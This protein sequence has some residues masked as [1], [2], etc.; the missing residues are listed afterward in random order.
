M[1][2]CSIEFIFFFLPVFLLVYFLVPQSWSNVVLFAGSLFYYWYGEREYFILILL[3]L[4][5]HYALW[6]FCAGKSR[7]VR[8]I[9]LVIMLAYSFGMLFTFKYLDFFTENWNLLGAWLAAR[10]SSIVLPQLEPP[11]LTLPLGISFYT[12]QISAYAMDVCRGQVKPEKRFAS[13]GAFLC[14]F[15]QLIAGPIVLY[16]Q[17]SRQLKRRKI[18]WHHMENGIKTFII[19]LSLKMLLANT[20][21]TLWNQVQ[22]WGVSSV[23][24]ALVWV[25]ALAYTFQIY[26]DFQGYSMMA[27]GLGEMLGF[28]IPRNFNHPYTAVSVTDF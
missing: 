27:M 10:G 11:H 16:H 15:P 12:F 26:F 3:S 20:F 2:F 19:G 17:V 5:I 9:C 7:R 14:M 25:G 8:R 21:G 13:L 22:T 4:V 28:R 24:V 6:L 23:S 18:N 1:L